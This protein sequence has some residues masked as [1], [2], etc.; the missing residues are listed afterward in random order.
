MGRRNHS[1]RS[2]H[3]E[4]QRPPRPLVLPNALA[5]I[6]WR[7]EWWLVRTIGVARAQKIYRCPGCDHEIQPGTSHVL[8]WPERGSQH[9]GD[10][11]QRRHW[12][13][14]CWRKRDANY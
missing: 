8:V 12:H 7:Y 10:I 6:W 11:E 14:T 9:T 5:R 4:K 2:A 1:R 3:S 13:S